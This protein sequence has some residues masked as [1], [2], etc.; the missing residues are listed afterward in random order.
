MYLLVYIAYI[1]KDLSSFSF[2][3]SNCMIIFLELQ[4]SGEKDLTFGN[5]KFSRKYWLDFANDAKT[6]YCHGCC[7]LQSQQHLWTPFA[8][9]Q[10]SVCKQISK[11]PTFSPFSSNISPFKCFTWLYFSDL[12]DFHATSWLSYLKMNLLYQAAMIDENIEENL[13]SM[14]DEETDSEYVILFAYMI[15]TPL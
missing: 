11:F 7:S 4:T 3:K 2:F 15:Y 14:L 6:G 8:R 5:L 9:N 1:E 13:F 12:E 10:T